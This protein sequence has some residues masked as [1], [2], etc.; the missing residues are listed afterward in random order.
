M[1]EQS[2][3]A[4]DL[5]RGPS[6]ILQWGLPCDRPDSWLVLAEEELFLWIPAFLTMGLACLANAARCGRI[7]CYITGPLSLLALVYVGVSAFH[8]VPMDAGYFLDIV[9]GL[10]IL[11]FLAEFPLGRYRKS[12]SANSRGSTACL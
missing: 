11:A 12:A 1:S 7:H 4:R 9:L 8:L 5:V 2:C 10:T 3:K 6:V